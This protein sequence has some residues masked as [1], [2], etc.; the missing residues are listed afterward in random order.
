MIEA[1]EEGL[2]VADVDGTGSE[3]GG[4]RGLEGFRRC[5]G[6]AQGADVTGS[7]SEKG[8]GEGGEQE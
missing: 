7:Y 4:E 6:S 8:A 2:E 1:V 3:V 5:L